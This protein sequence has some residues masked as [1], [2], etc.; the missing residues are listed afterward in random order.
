[1]RIVVRGYFTNVQR[2]RLWVMNTKWLD[3]QCNCSDKTKEME[4]L[5]IWQSHAAEKMKEV[6]EQ[7]GGTYGVV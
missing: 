1:M 6:W 2:H 5:R 4:L 3:W 7:R